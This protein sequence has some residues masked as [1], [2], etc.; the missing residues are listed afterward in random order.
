MADLTH[1]LGT[2][3]GLIQRPVA[4]DDARMIPIAS[5]PHHGL[6]DGSRMRLLL[7]RP[8]EPSVRT[9]L[10]TEKRINDAHHPQRIEPF[11]GLELGRVYVP[12]RD[13]GSTLVGHVWVIDPDASLTGDRLRSFG[14]SVGD[15]LADPAAAHTQQ[16]RDRSDDGGIPRV[17]GAHPA[18]RVLVVRAV[19]DGVIDPAGGARTGLGDA[20]AGEL[21]RAAGDLAVA[22]G[23]LDD[24]DVVLTLAGPAD[25]VARPRL[26]GVL[27]RARDGLRAGA[28]PPYLVPRFAVSPRFAPGGPDRPSVDALRD[29]L[30]AFEHRA[31][32]P[33]VHYAEDVPAYELLGELRRS[34]GGRALAVPGD[35]RALLESPRGRTLALTL[36]VFLDS[37]GNHKQATESLNVHR[38]TLYYRLDQAAELTGLS[39]H[40]GVAR[41][42]LHFGLTLAALRGE[43]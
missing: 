34:L 5:T 21:R 13:R 3:A 6:I 33:A 23:T 19:P 8:A 15:L 29:I 36:K 22:H 40:D 10:L 11:P 39:L 38:G 32:G 31:E 7:G 17:A 12:V 25:A 20:L 18:H 41:L 42:R 2:L 24:G 30:M 35:V 28:L 4:L 43:L 37:G 1:T 16:A 14:R 27:A 26:D 9:R